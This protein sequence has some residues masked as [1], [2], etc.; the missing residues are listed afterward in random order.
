MQSTF[1]NISERMGPFKELEWRLQATSLS[2]STSVSELLNSLLDVWAQ[3]PTGTHQTLA[4]NIPKRMETLCI[5]K[6]DCSMG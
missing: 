2:G 4:E 5:W 6:R 1:R 3:V